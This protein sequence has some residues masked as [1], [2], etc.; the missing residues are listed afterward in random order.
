MIKKSEVISKIGSVFLSQTISVLVVTAL[1]SG[2]VLLTGL[3]DLPGICNP[4][5]ANMLLILSL[6]I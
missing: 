1:F 3:N 2:L 4:T 6:I 5:G